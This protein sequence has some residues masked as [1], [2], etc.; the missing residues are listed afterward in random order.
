MEM[1]DAE[2]RV[3]PEKGLVAEFKECFN[4]LP[5]PGSFA[6]KDCA[7]KLDY[8]NDFLKV[9]VE[10]QDTTP[11]NKNSGWWSWNGDSI[12]LGLARR[13]LR[14]RSEND[15]ADFSAQAYSEYTVA[16]TP[17]GDEVC[18]TITWDMTRYPVDSKRAGIVDEAI[19]PRKVEHNGKAWKYQ[20]SIPWE[21]LN[22]RKPEAGMTLRLA[23]QYNDR[24]PKE[25]DVALHQF[26]GFKM[27]L[28][29]PKNFG[30]VTIRKEP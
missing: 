1:F 16:K 9:E 17:L 6:F 14:K 18:R 12:Q 8:D 21:F 23:A 27:K 11:I 13:Y 3:T 19:A 20:V 15:F 26:E 2:V 10:V 25:Q 28:N 7:F 30:W 29:A 4:F 22:I 5:L 24:V